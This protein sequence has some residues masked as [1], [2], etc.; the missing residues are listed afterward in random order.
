MGF[1]Q[2]CDAWIGTNWA[3]GGSVFAVVQLAPGGLGPLGGGSSTS[4]GRVL[5][6]SRGSLSQREQLVELLGDAGIG[7]ALRAAHR[8]G[9]TRENDGNH[10]GQ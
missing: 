4:C 10:L 1:F 6:L 7:E 8:L 3:S 5:S 9:S 2:G